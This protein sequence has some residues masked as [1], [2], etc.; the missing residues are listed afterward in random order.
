MMETQLN[1]TDLIYRKIQVLLAITVISIA[2]I[3]LSI[4]I[5]FPELK[6]FSAGSMKINT[7]L[8][9]IA[10]GT[11]LILMGRKNFR[12]RLVTLLSAFIT[13]IG[14]Y[15]L[16]EYFF[17]FPDA[18][19]E[20]F[21]SDF[22]SQESSLHPG[23]MSP[24]AA[25]LFFLVGM[26]FLMK[27]RNQRRWSELGLLLFIPVFSIS[28]LV[29]L[30][31]LY[32]LRSFYS[33]GPYIRISWQSALSFLFL[34]VGVFF[35]KE[36]GISTL[37]T[38]KGP[39]GMMARRLLPTI[40]IFPVIL[41]YAWLIVRRNDWVS[42]ELA[43]AFYILIIISVFFIVIM[44]IARKIDVIDRERSELQ[45]KLRA[46]LSSSPLFIW[47]VDLQGKFTICEGG[48]LSR[49]N[50]KEEDVVGKDF[51]AFNRENP[52]VVDYVNRAM[53][54][55]HFFAES[56]FMNRFHNSN[57]AP[58]KDAAG[59][60]IGVS[61]VTIDISELKL[62]QSGYLMERTNLRNLFTQTPEIFGIIRGKDY[63]FEYANEALIKLYGFNP[64]GKSTAS[65]RPE[66]SESLKILDSVYETGKT[67]HLV[68]MSA[69]VNGR[70]CFFNMTYAARKDEEGKIDG[71]MF[72]G[73]DVTEQV[74]T[75]NDL[76]K[77]VQARDE[78]LSIASH[79]LKTPITSFLLQIQL[80]DHLRKRGDAKAYEEKRVNTLVDMGV[81]QLLRI[82][83]L[84]DD[85]LDIARI[86]TGRLSFRKEPVRLDEVLTEVVDRMNYL[87]EKEL[88]ELTLAAAP[89]IV[90]SLDRV[91][92]EQVITNV[93]TNALRYG[94]KKPVHVKLEKAHAFAVI[95]V[96][97][98]GLGMSSDILDKIFNRYER[99]VNLHEFSGLGLGLYISRQIIEAHG[100]K[101]EASSE[102]PGLGS[103]I[104]ISIPL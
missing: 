29:L 22:P 86:N 65:A 74:N 6:S 53:K 30:G 10:S 55:E 89:E 34:S 25:A 50:L 100:G 43:I 4:W 77:A 24:I 99:G 7:C 23:R 12:P 68:E 51:Y 56:Q 37:L 28:F 44:T 8:G 39:G 49:M 31:Y 13:L 18:I 33:Y 62:A 54:G 11:V 14:F 9:L 73:M 79:E 41:G 20:F 32:N 95:S 16:G 46:V 94:Q 69:I 72:L 61:V 102:G 98:H 67:V 96:T 80:V 59:K 26:G 21:I 88:T 101:I 35:L 3:L 76:Q 58:M 5:A 82:N 63:V 70:T 1:R 90:L 87:F 64:T 2:V 66:A 48:G 93:L 71:I 38:S 19:D 42:R 52:T 60:I 92:M 57:Y 17:D 75:R 91:R 78:F 97:D 85:M 15:T 81:K 83:R 103:V 36:R 40:S 47:G 27:S 104:R 84:V 45:E